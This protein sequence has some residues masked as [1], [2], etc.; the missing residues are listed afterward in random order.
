MDN[1][2]FKRPYYLY[3]DFDVGFDARPIHLDLE[4]AQLRIRRAQLT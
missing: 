3:F 1:T 4:I 2:G